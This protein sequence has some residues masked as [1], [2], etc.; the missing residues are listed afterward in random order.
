MGATSQVMCCCCTVTVQKSAG[1]VLLIIII[2]R[3]TRTLIELARDQPPMDEW[4]DEEGEGEGEVHTQRTMVVFTSQHCHA[5]LKWKGRWP[6]GC[7]GQAAEE[8][9]V[10]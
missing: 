6:L 1:S 7:S 9:G 8:R 2:A 5:H 3:Q 4:T 10:A